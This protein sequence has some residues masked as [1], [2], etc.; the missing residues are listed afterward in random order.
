[1]KLPM[2]SGGKE[3]HLEEASF[4]GCINSEILAVLH[5]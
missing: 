4:Q 2:F 5:R 3:V 1:M